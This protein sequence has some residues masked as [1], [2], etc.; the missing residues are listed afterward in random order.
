MCPVEFVRV[1]RIDCI[2]LCVLLIICASLCVCVCVC[3]S[4]C[5]SYPALSRCCGEADAKAK[6][7]DSCTT[8]D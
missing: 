5:G 2:G 1:C 8:L 3:V 7:I 6:Q 4:S